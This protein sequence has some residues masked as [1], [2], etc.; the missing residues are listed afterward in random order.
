MFRPATR[1]F[2]A[3][4]FIVL[5][6]H[7]TEAAHQQESTPAQVLIVIPSNPMVVA[8]GQPAIGTQAAATP[9][10][11]GVKTASPT[12]GIINALCSVTLNIVGCGFDPDTVT[13]NCDTNGDGVPDNPIKLKNLTM[14]GHNLVLATLVPV[15]DQ[16]P[17]TAFPLSCCGGIATLTL[18][19]TF[20]AADDNIFGPFTQTTSCPIDLGLRAP[21]VLS[22][23]PTGADCAGPQDIVIPGACFVAANGSSNVTSVFAVDRANPGNVIQAAR[24]VVLNSNLVD[25]LFNFG[26]ADAGKTFLI[27]V[28]G[29]NGTSRNLVARPAGA[30]AGCPLG[31][32]QGIQVSFQCKPINAPA[33]DVAII[34]ACSLDRTANGSYVLNIIGS[35][36]K[37]DATVKINGAAVRK[38]KLKELDVGTGTYRAV[39]VKGGLCGLL[40]GLL[41]ITNPGAPG[42]QP[43]SL[44]S[45]CE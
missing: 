32:E 9:D 29:P 4:F 42:S 11:L 2:V 20:N 13:L 19:R 18:S 27:Y 24:F 17:G 5:S 36:I 35:N 10:S 21:V 1:A 43:Y 39:Q 7:S 23:S 34:Q 12:A 41:V 15:S 37:L 6:F 3:S 40:P 30:A 8:P 16:L 45:G 25:A 28:S 33:E 26:V 38:V 31:N 22:A 44:A 14:A